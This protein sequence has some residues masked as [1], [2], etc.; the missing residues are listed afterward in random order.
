MFMQINQDHK[1][2]T[3]HVKNS[4]KILLRRNS[5]FQFL[6]SNIRLF[7]KLSKRQL[8]KRKDHMISLKK[9]LIQGKLKIL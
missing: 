1:G 9:F 6:I 4:L 3:H 7:Q 8:I 2:Q 5:A